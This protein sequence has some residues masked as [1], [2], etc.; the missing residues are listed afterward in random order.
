[1]ESD[2][3]RLE[4]ILVVKS[5]FRLM[6]SEHQLRAEIQAACK[7]LDTARPGTPE[8]TKALEWLA[9]LRRELG[10]P[11]EP[12][13]SEDS[14]NIRSGPQGCLAYVSTAIGCGRRL[15]EAQANA[16]RIVLCV[17]FCAGI[18]DELLKAGGLAQMRGEVI[19]QYQAD[20]KALRDQIEFEAMQKRRQ[21]KG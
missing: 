13:H 9:E 5:K 14:V 6:K 11:P 7:D 2:S 20:I 19:R 17:N 15:M 21:I 18:E 12:W 16:D 4:T 10:R 3:R 1:M 8:R